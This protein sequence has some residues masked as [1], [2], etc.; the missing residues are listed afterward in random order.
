MDF[1]TRH[2]SAE[3]YITAVLGKLG[4]YKMHL[5]GLNTQKC[6]VMIVYYVAYLEQRFAELSSALEQLTSS[7]D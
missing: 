2:I 7:T 4:L 3:F 1:Q 5:K 6:Y